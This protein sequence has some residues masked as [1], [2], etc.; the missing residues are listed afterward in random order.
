M[1]DFTDVAKLNST[2]IFSEIIRFTNY[3]AHLLE[4][5]RLITAD[6][7]GGQIFISMHWRFDKNDWLLQ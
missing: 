7:F 6:V 5:A 2:Q 4:L 1:C 3:P